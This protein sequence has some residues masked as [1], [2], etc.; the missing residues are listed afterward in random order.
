M[1][2]DKPKI[3]FITK[4]IPAPAYNGGALRN[5]EWL[6][7]LSKKYNIYL[8]GFWDKKFKNNLINELDDLNISIIGFEYKNS[9]LLKLLKYIIS[10]ITFQPYILYQYYANKTRKIIE[11][12]IRENEIEF[13]FCAE[14]A[15]V[16]YCNKKTIGN[17][18]VYFDDHNVE[19]KLIERTV[20]FSKNI[21]KLVL[22]RESVLIKR[23]ER[24]A[25]ENTRKTFVVSEFDKKL[26]LDNF[27]RL[28]NKIK[29]VNNSFVDNDG[30]K[31][32]KLDEVP[33]IIFTGNLG[34]LPNKIGLE[35][36]LLNIWP[37]VKTKIE[38]VKLVIIGSN[39]DFF[40]KFIASD[41]G[42]EVYNN[43]N[44]KE[45]NKLLKKAWLG[46]V[47]LYFGSGSRIKILEYWSHGKPVVSTKIGAEGL[48]LSSG[49]ILTDQDLKFAN[50]IIKLLVNKKVVFEMGKKNYSVF[51]EYYVNE[52][53]YEDTLFNAF[54]S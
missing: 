34:W 52:K 30:L 42:I 14:L 8:V 44:D 51:K 46:I 38:N 29:I 49:T 54:S 28:E 19:F 10:I 31:L 25:I 37:S 32:N 47:P 18:P 11:K 17:I 48:N 6:K 4:F 45:K 53:V 39:A 13:I 26:L 7:F 12:L 21:K 36:F 40:S 15:T 33:S 3:I 16:Q 1:N 23:I 35:H 24:Q 9:Y 27:N 20:L 41:S 50:E 2:Q 43:I 22:I 5:K